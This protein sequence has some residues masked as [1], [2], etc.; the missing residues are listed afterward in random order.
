MFKAIVACSSV[1]VLLIEAA[2]NPIAFSSVKYFTKI[3][4]N[5]VQDSFAATTLGASSNVLP[6]QNSTIGIGIQ[7]PS[8]WLKNDAKNGVIFQSPQENASDVFQEQVGI[9]VSSSHSPQGM[10]SQLLNQEINQLR[11]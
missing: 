5:K 2:L 9:S 6:Y 11:S 3:F 10:S 1:F 4:E 7:Y 8:D